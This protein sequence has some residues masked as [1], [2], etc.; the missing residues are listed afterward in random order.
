M[1]GHTS[2]DP[3]FSSGSWRTLPSLGL[4]NG[5]AGGLPRPCST[6]EV[7]AAGLKFPLLCGPRCHWQPELAGCST[8]RI[9][10]E[11]ARQCLRGKWLTFVGDSQVR[12][13]MRVFARW[14]GVYYRLPA[15][16]RPST[17]N[18]SEAASNFY[19][20][21]DVATSDDPDDATLLSF[22][23]SGPECA[24]RVRAHLSNQRSLASSRMLSHTR[25]LSRRLSLC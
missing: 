24:H 5:T 21:W 2:E 6:A 12:N 20:D 19:D 1:R 9:E 4:D 16:M 13:L 25:V 15:S 17:M 8:V 10:P 7:L 14:L 18:D 11:E 22:R 23:F 3:C